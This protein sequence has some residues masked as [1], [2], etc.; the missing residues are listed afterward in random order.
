MSSKKDKFTNKDR[1]YMNLAINLARG[2]DGLTGLNPS[3]GCVIEK[4]NSIISTG[5]TSING[6]PHAEYNA[7][8]KNI[9]FKGSNIYLTLEPCSHFGKTPPCTNLIKKKK[10]KKVYYAINDID[11]RSQNKSQKILGLN[12]IIVKKNLLKKR[13]KNFYESYFNQKNDKY[14]IIDAKIAVSKDFFTINKKDKWI[15]N[16]FSRNVVHFLRTQYDCI[17]TTSKTVNNDNALL[18]CRIK[19]L[20]KKSPNIA[21]I[22]RK[23]QIDKSLELFKKKLNRKIIIFTYKDKNEKK[24]KNL[25]NKKIIVIQINKHENKLYE[26]AEIMKFLKKKNYFRLLVEAGLTFTS[27]LL[28][29]KKIRDIYIFQ[30]NFKLKNNGKNNFSPKYLKMIKTQNKEKVFLYG[31]NLYK[32]RLK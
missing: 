32:E 12:K 28:K 10:I 20:E 29:E 16:R 17:L 8:N 11:K 25:K 6:R 13:G 30:S 26:Y 2:Q 3:V 24:I 1:F 27:F 18:D 31:D 21:I 7:L 22:D 23:F 15:T 4:N 9:N 14:P 19:G 5:F